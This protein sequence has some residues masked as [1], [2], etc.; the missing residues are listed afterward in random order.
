MGAVNTWA[1]PR[2]RDG[3]SGLYLSIIANEAARQKGTRVQCWAILGSRLVDI[4]SG[5]ASP[6]LGSVRCVRLIRQAQ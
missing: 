1:G 6:G 4:H 3:S 5:Y 2:G